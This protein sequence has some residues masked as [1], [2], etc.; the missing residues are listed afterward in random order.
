[1]FLWII[2][3]GGISDSQDVHRSWFESLFDE[4]TLLP[5]MQLR[6]WRA[7]EECLSSFIWL[8]FVLNEEAVKFRQEGQVLEM[9][10]DYET[11]RYD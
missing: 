2:M 1:M 8:D 5:S 10:F 7:V 4:I 11:K 6:K 3:L 9:P